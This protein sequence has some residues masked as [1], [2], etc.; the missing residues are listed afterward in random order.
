MQMKSL[1]VGQNVVTLKYYFVKLS[2]IP[3]P[4]I[5]RRTECGWRLQA[6]LKKA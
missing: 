3:K 5:L 2:H 1:A 6:S 4:A